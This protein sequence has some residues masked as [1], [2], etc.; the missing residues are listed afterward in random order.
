M[1]MIIKGCIWMGGK[2]MSQPF[3]MAKEAL[4]PT[5]PYNV[6]GKIEEMELGVEVEG[7]K[8]EWNIGKRRTR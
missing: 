4:V 1:Y 6:L 7:D 2:R 5:K 8:V 3:F